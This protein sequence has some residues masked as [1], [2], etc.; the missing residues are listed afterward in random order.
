MMDDLIEEQTAFCEE[1]GVTFCYPTDEDKWAEAT[2]SMYDKYGTGY[3]EL[4]QQ[5]KDAQ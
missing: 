5:I 2:A 3:E 1:Q 4:I